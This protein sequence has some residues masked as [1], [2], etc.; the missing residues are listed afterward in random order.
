MKRLLVHDHLKAR[1]TLSEGLLSILN[2]PS[3]KPP[4][5]FIVYSAA[6]LIYS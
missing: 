4:I 6:S 3:L 5:L 2:R 1:I